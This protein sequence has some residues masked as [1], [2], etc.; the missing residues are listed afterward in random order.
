LKIRD[1]FRG[2]AA[3][4]T[5]CV[6]RCRLCGASWRSAVAVGDNAAAATAGR[7]KVKVETGAI[8]SSRTASHRIASHT[9]EMLETCA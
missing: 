1:G 3:W 7:P 5:V 9:A 8:A 6:R 2:A 4:S